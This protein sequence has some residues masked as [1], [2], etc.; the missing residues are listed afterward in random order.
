MM[1]RHRNLAT[2]DKIPDSSPAGDRTVRPTV[3]VGGH[4]LDVGPDTGMSV[5]IVSDPTKEAAEQGSELS[6]A[7]SKGDRNA[8]MTEVR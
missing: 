1:G 6:R 8:S 2:T 3:A 5:A 4:S 7:V